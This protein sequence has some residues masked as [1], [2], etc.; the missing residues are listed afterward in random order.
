M[1][2]LLNL[3]GLLHI[4]GSE[5]VRHLFLYKGYTKT[6]QM[7]GLHD[8]T[9]FTAWSKCLLVSVFTVFLFV[10]IPS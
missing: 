1:V 6:T 2:F 10:L 3:K 4:T 9:V 8:F 5:K 7:K